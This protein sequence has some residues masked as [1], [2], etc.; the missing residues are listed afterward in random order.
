M[1][2][3]RFNNTCWIDNVDEYCSINSCSMLTKSNNCYNVVGTRA[4]NGWWKKLVDRCQQ[5]WN[6][7]CW[8][9]TTVNNDCS[10]Q[11]LTGCSTTMRQVVDNIEQV[12]H[13]RVYTVLWTLSFLV[14]IHVNRLRIIH[15]WFCGTSCDS[16]VQTTMFSF[17]R[18][19]TSAS[20]RNVQVR[21]HTT[22]TFVINP[23]FHIHQK[24]KIAKN[25]SVNNCKF[26]LLT[27]VN[28]WNNIEC[29]ESMIRH[30]NISHWSP[31]SHPS[32]AKI[33]DFRKQNDRKNF[34]CKLALKVLTADFDGSRL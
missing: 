31:R 9:W 26:L 10:Q 15:L 3:S 14:V 32:K 6:N 28:E 5:W 23:P 1:M 24:E 8:T 7:D 33:A 13:M 22:K 17:W 19:W 4:D 20:V 18:M 21:N 29:P 25:A 11:L 16:G 27:D 30:L 12:V 2:L 34:K